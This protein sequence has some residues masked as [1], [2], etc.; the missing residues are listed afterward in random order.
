ML[1][2][3]KYKS[4]MEIFAIHNLQIFDIPISKNQAQQMSYRV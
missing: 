1:N 4:L 3:K 2:N